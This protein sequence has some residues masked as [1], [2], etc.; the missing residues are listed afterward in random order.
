MPREGGEH[1]FQEYFLASR[2]SYFKVGIS[3]P[4]ILQVVKYKTSLQQNLMIGHVKWRK[5]VK[6]FFYHFN[7]CARNSQSPSDVLRQ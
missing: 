2:A 7:K 3:C 6:T 5:A 1:V 4:Q